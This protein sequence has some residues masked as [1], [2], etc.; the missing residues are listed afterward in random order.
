MG[1]ECRQVWALCTA[2]EGRR[3][4]ETRARKL[5]SGKTSANRGRKTIVPFP[6]LSREQSPDSSSPWPG[7]ARRGS[8]AAGHQERRTHQ[9]RDSSWD[10]GQTQDVA[11][12]HTGRGH[13]DNC[14]TYTWNEDSGTLSFMLIEQGNWDTHPYTQDRGHGDIHPYTSTQTLFFSSPQRQQPCLSY[15]LLQAASSPLRWH[16]ALEPGTEDKHT[17]L[18]LRAHSPAGPLT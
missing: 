3:R 5:D 11:P 8:G 1:R 16:S 13:W 7:N 12:V 9:D 2:R 14:H 6:P 4:S 15:I 18:C 17:L 10:M